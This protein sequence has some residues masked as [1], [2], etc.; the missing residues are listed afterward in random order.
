MI[1]EIV[2]LTNQT[3]KD[4]RA[5]HMRKTREETGQFLAEGLKII[6]DA[7]DQGFS[8]QILVYG[9]DADRHPLLTRAI[10]QTLKARGQVLEVTREILEKISR[11]DNPQMVIAVFA[12]QIKTL[13]DI[14]PKDNDVWVAL[15]QVRDPGNLGTII[16][17]ADAAGIGGVILIGDCVDPFSVET[18]R[19]TMGSIFA[20]PIV[21]CTQAEF[22]AD[23]A[24]W[25]GSI[26]G[27]LLTATHDHRSA[28]YQRPT[29]ILMGTEQSGLSPEVA[30]ICDTHVKI[31]MRGRADSLN[32][33]VATG[34]MIYAATE[35]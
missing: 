32:L 25:T 11:K 1:K 16:R 28:P 8:P 23:R 22:I 6:I 14:N 9:K 10:D 12:Q 31:P 13:S 7:L 24:R 15:E 33:S 19:A 2:S 3:I 5:L 34:I 26:V 27:T 29:L 21:K 20:L 17:T 35:V 18:V 30:A 4:I